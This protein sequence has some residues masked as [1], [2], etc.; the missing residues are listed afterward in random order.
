MTVTQVSLGA[1][2]AHTNK[3]SDAVRAR[4]E[5]ALKDMRREHAQ[6][7]I[8]SVARRAKVTRNSIH[9]RGDL[10]ALIRA[11]RPLAAVDADTPPPATG[12]ETSIVA[13]LRSRLTAKDAQIAELKAALRDRDLINQRSAQSEAS[14]V[15]DARCWKRHQRLPQSEDV[16]GLVARIIAPC[17]PSATS[18]DLVLKIAR[19][20]D[21]IVITRLDRLGRSVL[22]LIQLGAQLQERGCCWH[23]SA[24]SAIRSPDLLQ[25]NRK[26]IRHDCFRRARQ[27]GPARRDRAAGCCRVDLLRRNDFHRYCSLGRRLPTRH[28]Q[29]RARRAVRARTQAGNHRR[30]GRRTADRGGWG[31]G[32]RHHPDLRSCVVPGRI[33]R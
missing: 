13:A 4:I 33:R 29:L 26:S 22:N 30:R 19:K 3:R 1:L 7:T 27:G 31:R 5:K 14:R 20:D 16:A 10:V 12:A 8:S 21:T 17:S 23:L 18:L 28:L 9:R 11:H 32:P 25:T 2:A 24:D 15:G 6:I